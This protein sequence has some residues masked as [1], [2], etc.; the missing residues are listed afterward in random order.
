M[1]SLTGIA[2]A[3]LP[4]KSLTVVKKMCSALGLVDVWRLFNPAGRDYT[5]LSAMHGVYTR[6]DYFFISKYRVRVR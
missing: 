2:P 3:K 6:I 1:Q 4:P 5:F